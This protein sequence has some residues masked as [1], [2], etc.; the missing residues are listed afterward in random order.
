MALPFKTVRI[1]ACDPEQFIVMTDNPSSMIVSIVSSPRRDGY[2]AT[3]T[4]AVVESARANGKEVKEF[5][6]NDMQSYRQCQNCEAC[7]GSGRCVLNDDISPIIDE[8]RDADGLILCTSI[9]FNDSN[10]LF[11]MLLDRFYCFLDI[12]ASTI[13]P[14]GKK[15]AIV[16]TAGADQTSA[17]RVSSDLEKV[18]SQHFFCEPV[19]RIAHCTWMMPPGMPMDEDVIAQAKDIGNRF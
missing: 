4:S 9:N 7:K 2:G 18:M 13:L 16:V 10:G 19:G 3:I 17:D 1:T 6:L 5:F 12:N 14:K 11:K 15:V 8:I